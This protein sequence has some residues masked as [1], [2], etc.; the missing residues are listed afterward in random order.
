MFLLLEIFGTVGILLTIS[1]V[2]P[3]FLFAAVVIVLSYWFIGVCLTFRR[4][5]GVMAD[6][7]SQY[8]YLASSR[9]LKRSESV[10]RSPMFSV[11]GEVLSGVA[12]IR[13]FGD[14][15]RFT[16]QIFSLLNINNRPFFLL[17][18]TN[19]WLSVRVDIAGGF[20]SFSAACFVL[21]QRDM[22]AALAGFI[23]SFAI[24][25]NERILW[26]VLRSLSSID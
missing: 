12:S 17:W 26:L 18:Q 3:Q 25:F 10:T 6:S 1:T 11:F 2:L 7:S 21:Y 9:E 23:L 16:K 24:A 15:A 20:V 22:D 5:R 14:S 13:A 8:I 19:R 4:L